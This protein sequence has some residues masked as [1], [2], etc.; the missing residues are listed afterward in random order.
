MLRSAVLSGLIN[1]A[2]LGGIVFAIRAL[3]YGATWDS[4]E[5]AV[6]F[7]LFWGLVSAALAV[8]RARRGGT[9]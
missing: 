1:A 7:A 9:R 8:Y 5:H 2:V 4:L 3:R 6:G